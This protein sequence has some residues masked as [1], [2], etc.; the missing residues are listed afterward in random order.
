MTKPGES[1]NPDPETIRALLEYSQSAARVGGWQ[2]DIATGELYWTDETYRIHDTNPAEFNPTVDAGVSYFLPESRELISAALERAV[3]VGE[4]YALELETLTTKGRRIDVFTT[5]EVSL[6]EGKPAKLTGIFQDITARKEAEREL[7][8]ERLRVLSILGSAVDGIIL[9]NSRGVVLSFNAAAEAIFKFGADDVLGKNISMLMP[10][11][12]RGSH[13][14]YLER[15]L[16]GHK[17][18]IIGIGREVTGQRST[19]ERF[20]MDLSISEFLDGDERMFTGVIRD[21]TKEKQIQAQLIQ[22]QKLESVSQL[23]SG[24]AHD[25]NNLLSVIMGNLEVLKLGLAADAPGIGEID[26]AL[27]AAERGADITKRML[28]FSRLRVNQSGALPALDANVLLG[29]MKLILARTLG[30][31]Y[32]IEFS[33]DCSSIWVCLD[34][35]EFENVILNLAV[36][37]RDAMPK[38]GAISMRS[39]KVWL[40]KDEVAGVRAGH[41]MKLEFCDEGC[42]LPEGVANRIFE[43]FFSTKDGKGSGLG[44]SMAFSFVT[45]IRGYIRTYS[46]QG[47]GTEFHLYIPIA[48]SAQETFEA[49]D[50]TEIVG[51]SETILVTDD[52]PELLA[53]VVSQ[54][55]NLGYQVLAAP[56][57]ATALDVLRENP[58]IDLL[59]TDVMLPGELLGTELA[60]RAQAQHP[61]LK[62]ILTSGFPQKVSEDPEFA[63][64]AD[65]VL[66]KPYRA[67]ELARRVREE[68]DAS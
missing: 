26:A 5:C 17:A 42:G 59:L 15:Y 19:G 68:L 52:E 13:D 2:L 8:Q 22:T 63:H 4:G 66:Q 40:S 9:I 44:L 47:E 45:Q 48:E 34:A 56:E 64:M 53:V 11:P 21:L 49:A 55:K 14:G 30:A 29:E 18:Q 43:P 36:N 6:H 20:P 12:D 33:T 65:R 1:G 24:L 67:A 54:L 28:K 25:F 58:G 16:G 27:R 37:A 57:A 50:D 51:G 60:V 35:A 32:P 61:G 3:S 38:G 31:P 46:T 62:I 7:K 10:E 39:S 41:F 23:S